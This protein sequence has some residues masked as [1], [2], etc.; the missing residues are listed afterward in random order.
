MNWLPFPSFPSPFPFLEEHPT[1]FH[2]HRTSY[3]RLLQSETRTHRGTQ[4]Y[5]IMMKKIWSND[6]CFDTSFYLLYGHMCFI[7]I[8]GNMKHFAVEETH[9]FRGEHC[10]DRH[11]QGSVQTGDTVL[12]EDAS[13]LVVVY[14]WKTNAVLTQHQNTSPAP[15]F[16][17]CGL[18]NYTGY[19]YGYS[20]SLDN[21]W[22][23][24][25]SN[26][27]DSVSVRGRQRGVKC[28]AWPCDTLH[29]CEKCSLTLSY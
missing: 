21:S 3:C 15:C 19:Y 8:R 28:D 24:L 29:L 13:T 10:S 23:R 5:S 25:P 18:I 14:V 22:I 1:L 16:H 9:I 26:K 7:S 11:T 27:S 6:S 2:Q 17:H 12:K 20:S 4:E